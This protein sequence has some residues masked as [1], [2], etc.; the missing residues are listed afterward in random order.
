MIKTDTSKY[1][2]FVTSCRARRAWLEILRMADIAWQ[3]LIFH[4][5]IGT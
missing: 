2:S 4:V 5:N 3:H 1:S